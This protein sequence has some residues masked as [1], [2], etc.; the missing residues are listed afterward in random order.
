MAKWYY[1]ADGQQQGP[2]EPA[3]LKHLA[4]TGKLKPT[5]KVRRE[6]MAEWYQAKQIKGLF[7][8]VQSQPA[9][10]RPVAAVTEPSAMAYRSDERKA[11]DDDGVLAEQ[12]VLQ[13]VSVVSPRQAARS[14][15]TSAGRSF[16]SWYEGRLGNKP[17]VVQI[18]SWLFY[19]FIWI[20]VWWWVTHDKRAGEPLNAKFLKRAAIVIGSG[21]LL[22]IS[23]AV[24]VSIIK[25]EFAQ[26]MLAETDSEYFLATSG[27][28]TF[29]G[30][31]LPPVAKALAAGK[32]VWLLRDHIHIDGNP[33]LMY[34]VLNKY[35]LDDV[36]YV[37]S[38]H[39][40]EF[41]R[42]NEHIDKRLDS[43]QNNQF[44]RLGGKR[45]NRY[46][47]RRSDSGATFEIQQVASLVD[48]TTVSETTRINLK[49][50][51][52]AGTWSCEFQ[53][54]DTGLPPFPARHEKKSGSGIVEIVNATKK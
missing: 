45:S 44:D 28:M 43:Q 17:I 18:V 14:Q 47:L 25:P 5:D 31:T 42:D 15:S 19:G 32:E 16:G 38:R 11:N 6:D 20:P 51:D 2:V 50:A 13:S 27:D 29:D 53:R 54:D 41:T 26:R 22:L 35:G 39:W 46:S 33:A 36:V 23:Y 3:A 37:R 48:T 7:A 40:E 4:T 34:L 30:E 21:F 52:R 9:G 49:P 8:P 1:L 24:L 10:R 12:H